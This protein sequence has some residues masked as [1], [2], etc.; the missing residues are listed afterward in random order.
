MIK[1][2]FRYNVTQNNYYAFKTSTIVI[3][4][5]LPL[6]GDGKANVFK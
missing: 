4:S 2:G 3:F 1:G 5:A 6:E